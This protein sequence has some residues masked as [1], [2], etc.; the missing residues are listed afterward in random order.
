[1]YW[2]IKELQ[3][4]YFAKPLEPLVS[5]NR[6]RMPPGEIQDEMFPIAEKARMVADYGAAMKSAARLAARLRKPVLVGEVILNEPWRPFLSTRG[7]ALSADQVLSL[8]AALRR[9]DALLRAHEPRKALAVIERAGP[10]GRGVAA[11]D[12]AAGRAHLML[13]DLAEAR[14]LLRLAIMEDGLPLRYAQK[15]N[16]AAAAAD[17]EG[18][19]FF[20]FVGNDAAFETLLRRG[21]GYGE[22]FA[23]MEHPN[24]LGHSFLSSQFVCALS[25]S[26]ALADGRSRC[27]D[28]R[29]AD[30]RAL[31]A[32]HERALGV[33]A[34]ETGMLAF[35]GASWH[36]ALSSLSVYPADFL[37]AAEG[38][39]RE[40][41]AVSGSSAH[42]RAAGA[43]VEAWLEK[44]RGRPE[45]AARLLNEAAAFEPSFVAGQW[46]L[47]LGHG[48]TMRALFEAGGVARANGRFASMAIH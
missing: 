31:A 20:R 14:R 18:A 16:E 4:T 29:A 15:L 26:P 45:G 24:L 36:Y 38:K 25:A 42:S 2:T 41:R 44:D 23:D 21:Y 46:T 19:G 32:G 1:M 43:L 6:F 37:D 17:A 47:D 30:L 7:A 34:E 5:P 13:G 48:R 3:R 27:R 40:Y 39:L 22:F 10:A 12:N 35:E 28:W 9:A 8:E 33:T 11:L